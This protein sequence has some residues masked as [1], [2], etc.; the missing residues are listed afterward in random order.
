MTFA[1][2]VEAL[3]NLLA[4]LCVSA[5][6]YIWKCKNRTSILGLMVLACQ[7][8]LYRKA[9]RWMRWH[10]KGGGSWK[11]TI[12]RWPKSQYTCY[13]THSFNVLC[14]A[15][16][17]KRDLREHFRERNIFIAYPLE[18]YR[19]IGIPCY[20]PPTMLLPLYYRLLCRLGIKE[21]FIRKSI[22]NQKLTDTMNVC[23]QS[24]SVLYILMLLAYRMYSK[25]KRE[26]WL[27]ISWCLKVAI[28]PCLSSLVHI[29]TSVPHLDPAPYP[30]LTGLHSQSPW[31]PHNHYFLFSFSHF[32]ISTWHLI[33]LIIIYLFQWIHN[34]WQSN[35][36]FFR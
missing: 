11:N 33:M 16:S 4:M 30:A 31:N 20:H 10:F 24:D 35:C 28:S 22:E 34:W 3:C 12:L 25:E 2:C 19:H 23:I 9:S 17:E 8:M 14:L 27:A 21:P 36:Y 5:L 6:L 26:H 15:Q 1:F 13:K 7:N 32:I 18:M 29:C